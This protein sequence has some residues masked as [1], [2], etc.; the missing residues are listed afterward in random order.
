MGFLKRFFRNI[1]YGTVGGFA[2]GALAWPEF[3]REDESLVTRFWMGVVGA[4]V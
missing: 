3:T 2:L 1:F 4:A